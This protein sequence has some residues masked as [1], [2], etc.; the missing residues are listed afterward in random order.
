MFDFILNPISQGLGYVMRFCYY[1]IG[2]ES[3]ALALFWF[4]LIVKI[5]LLPFGI[6]QQ[7]NQIKGAK[8]RPKMYAIEKKYAGR[9]DQ[10]TLRKKQQE[11]MD[12][13]QK[14]GYS[15]LSGCL[16]LLIQFPLIIVLYRI[17]QRPLTYICRLGGDAIKS[18]AEGT[19]VKNVANEIEILGK[20]SS[21]EA[22]PD[23]LTGVD[24]PNFDLFGIVDLSVAPAIISLGAIIPLL[25]FA[26]QFF[27]MKL[28][29]KLN[30]MMTQGQ[31][32]EAAMSMKIMDLM[33]PLM[34]LFMAFTLPAA[35][36]LYWLFQAI[37][38]IGQT[39]LLAKLMPM[40]TFTEEELKAAERELRGK[41]PRR[42]VGTGA[43]ESVDTEEPPVRP[44]SLHHIDDDDEDELPPRQPQAR[45]GQGGKKGG[46]S[47]IE[48]AP[49]KPRR[50]NDDE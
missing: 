21:P 14:E 38:G 39:L 35:L 15:P 18:L 16:P 23:V 44:R 43:D 20:I 46:R 32:P 27:T 22:F 42:R 48:A 36:G 40:P 10:V 6:K 25:V 24:L 47:S 13:Q 2:F 19:G 33:M 50:E 26:A 12:M 41:A 37:L 1:T 28:S 30:P 7:K 4:A 11:I 9:T 8:L 31:N 49:L 45:R 17:I 34:I 5:V 3:Y 29:R